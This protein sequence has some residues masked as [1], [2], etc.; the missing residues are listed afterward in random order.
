MQWLPQVRAHADIA[1]P[2][3]SSETGMA[4]TQQEA[5]RFKIHAIRGLGKT[6]HVFRL[7][8]L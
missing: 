4:Q 7:K 3:G 2:E 8:T 5:D 6:L 1:Q